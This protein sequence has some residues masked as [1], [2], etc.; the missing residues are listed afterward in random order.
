M[1]AKRRRKFNSHWTEDDVKRREA[2]ARVRPAGKFDMHPDQ[3]HDVYPAFCCFCLHRRLLKEP[4]FEG[5]YYA[6][7]DCKKEP[8]TFRK[9]GSIET[10]WNGLEELKPFRTGWDYCPSCCVCGTCNDRVDEYQEEGNQEDEVD[11]FIII[12]YIY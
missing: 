8:H 12:L 10:G 6:T 7:K 11:L 4:G 1:E 3:P 9:R 2:A 5:T